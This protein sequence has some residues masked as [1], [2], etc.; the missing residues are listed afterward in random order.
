MFL[1]ISQNSQENICARV[2]FLLKLRIWGKIFK[3]AGV[4][5]G[6]FYS[7]FLNFIQNETLSLVIKV[8]QHM[9]IKLTFK[10]NSSYSKN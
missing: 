7:F 2:S 4:F 9:Q 1:K 5:F 10:S 3:I 8:T 6:F